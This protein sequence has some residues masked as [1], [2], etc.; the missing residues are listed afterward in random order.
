[1]EARSKRQIAE[2]FGQYVP[3]EL[4]DRMREDPEK[5][6][7]EP[8][9][10]E[11]TILFSDVRGFT[12]ISEALSPEHLREYINTYLTDMSGIIRGGHK[13]TLDK[14]IGDAIMAFWG[15]PVDDPSHARNGVL[16]ALDMQHE[17]AELNRKFANRGWPPL[18][19]GVGVNSGGVRVGDMG[20][21]IRRAYTVMGDPVNVASRLEGRTKY[22]G[23]GCLVGEATRNLVKDVVFK[24][25]DK[26]KVKGKDEA[27]SIYE[28][29]AL[30][31]GA[32]KSVLD[33]IRLWQQTLRL[34][35][36]QQW[37]QVE[38][39]LLNLQRANPGCRLYE[40]YAERVT[41]HRRAPPPK[42]WDG[43]TVFDEK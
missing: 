25:I 22:Y 33:E 2:L 16:A 3:P 5:Y 40:L 18:K 1:V 23:V 34:Y 24:E 21:N 19:I 27:I 15:A 10:A 37:D 30:E 28:P 32:E 31:S 26:I 29:I 6:T 36:S 13:G 38:V 11:L 7:M 43:V 12:S 4:V 39:N 9:N 41:H 8:R 20:S 42:D 35:R 14:Y 17:C